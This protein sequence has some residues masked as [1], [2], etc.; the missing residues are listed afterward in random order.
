MRAFDYVRPTDP[1]QAVMTLVADPDA[2]FLAGGTT[3]LDLMKGGVLRP[4]RLVDI[5][6]LPLRTLAV[7]TGVLRVGA[8]VTMEELAGDR[9]VAERLPVL[10][11][12]LLAGAS[13]QLR[14]A[15]TVAGNLLQRTRCT[16]FRDPSWPCNKRDPGAGCSALAGVH[17]GHAILGTSE[18]CIATHPSDMAV[19]LVA[20]DAEVR[21][22]GPGG[23]RTVPLTRFYRQ[24]DRTPQLETVLGHGELITG[25]EVPLPAIGSRSG[26]LKVRDR[27]SYEFAL[28]SAAVV[29][30]E[31]GGVRVAL[32]G[33]AT[34]PWRAYRAEAVLRA[35][36]DGFAGAAADPGE[37]R[38]ADAP[39][40]FVAAAEAELR[41]AAP[42]RDN[43]YKVELVRR[44]MIRAL[45]TWAVRP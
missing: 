10:R 17:R 4:D 22:L 35:E 1:H 30:E 20:L 25:V 39:A 8:L 26:Y 23:S 27:A 38:V 34:V 18:H 19:A 40:A 37:S 36:P 7:E 43:R 9:V 5:T 41:A 14:N 2:Q 12:A 3:Q 29:A 16:Y 21:V 13:V 31:G 42:R 28:A 15:A 33:V 24:P 32:G 45:Q 6:R 11:E 44:T